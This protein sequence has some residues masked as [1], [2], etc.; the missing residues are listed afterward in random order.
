[1]RKIRKRI[2]RWLG[3]EQ[4]LLKKYP[5]TGVPEFKDRL[6]E[7]LRRLQGNCALS[8]V[9]I[10]DNLLFAV[11]YVVGAAVTGDIAEFGTGTGRTSNVI[12]AAMASFPSDK[13]LHLFDS[14]EGLPVSTVEADLNSPHVKQGTWG[15]GT[16][17]GISASEVRK[18]CEVFLPADKI[19]VYEGWF[20]KN[21]TKLPA[22]TKF[23]MIHLDCDLY[24]ST[25]DCLGYLF[26]HKMVSQGAILLFDD[27]FCNQS[28][29]EFGERKAWIELV[30]KHKVVAENCGPYAW[31]GQKFIFHSGG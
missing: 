2:S 19:V 21:M 31:G 29:N 4:R 20:S 15:P 10:A 16:C 27:W 18:Q 12:S 14:F 8:N 26:E 28:S 1:M 30:A 7:D 23:A 3:R 9:V 25:M 22:G 17:R 13:K 6:T 11:Q 5:L 24:E